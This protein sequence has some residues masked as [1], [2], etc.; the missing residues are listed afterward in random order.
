MKELSH[1]FDYENN[2]IAFSLNHE[3]NHLLKYH[4]EKKILLKTLS[5]FF[6]VSIFNPFSVAIISLLSFNL[7]LWPNL[8]QRK[9]QYYLELEADQIAYEK[10]HALGAIN[11]FNK[12]ILLHQLNPNPN[13]YDKDGNNLHSSH[14]KLTDRIEIA[15]KYI[16]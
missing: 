8:I 9:L 10:G 14:P 12:K 13:L 4:T 15:K 2:Q 11:H 6:L 7:Y 5:N 16:K 3:E 1:I